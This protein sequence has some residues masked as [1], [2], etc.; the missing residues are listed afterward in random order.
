L[1]S[2][3]DPNPISSELNAQC[4]AGSNNVSCTP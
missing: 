1:N 4:V 2:V 3:A